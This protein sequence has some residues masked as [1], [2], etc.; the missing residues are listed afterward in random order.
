MQVTVKFLALFSQDLTSTKLT[1]DALTV[2][3]CKHWLRCAPLPSFGGLI[4]QSFRLA[5][6]SRMSFPY[7]YDIA[8]V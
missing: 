4:M 2:V 8:L 6:K 1:P 7:K 3:N 5:K